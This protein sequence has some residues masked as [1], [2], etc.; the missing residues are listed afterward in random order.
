MRRPRR[1]SQ[2]ISAAKATSTTSQTV[3]EALV[4]LVVEV[5]F[6]ALMIWLWRRGRR[7]SAR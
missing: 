4:W 6:A 1:Q 3:P 5:A 7:I 2:I